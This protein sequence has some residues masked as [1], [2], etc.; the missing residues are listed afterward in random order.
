MVPVLLWK[1]R[2]LRSAGSSPFRCFPGSREQER[3]APKP[4]PLW[5][6][7]HRA[8]GPNPRPQQPTRAPTLTQPT[9]LTQLSLN[10]RCARH[11]VGSPLL[12]GGGRPFPESERRAAAL[13]GGQPRSS[14]HAVGSRARL[15]PLAGHPHRMPA[16]LPGR[17]DRPRPTPPV[18]SPAL[19]RTNDK[20]YTP[21]ERWRRAGAGFPWRLPPAC[22]GES[23]KV[24]PYRHELAS[25]GPACRVSE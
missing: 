3:A 22:C 1:S 21:L 20:T 24:P 23:I 16:E 15:G 18:A 9:A 4:L 6:Q 13:C 14:R 11:Q 19:G 5:G 8:L 2:G 7:D 10:G 12:Q 25:P 17:H